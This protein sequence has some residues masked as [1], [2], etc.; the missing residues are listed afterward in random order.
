[1]KFSVIL[2]KYTIS[3]QDISKSQITNYKIEFFQDINLVINKM[4][5]NNK[6]CWEKDNCAVARE[7]MFRAAES[8]KAELKKSKKLENGRRRKWKKGN[9]FDFYDYCSSECCC[10]KK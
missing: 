5:T 4:F 2:K 9:I 6:D 8:I 3:S 10:K 7:P 1:M